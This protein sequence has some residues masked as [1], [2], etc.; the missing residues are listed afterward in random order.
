MH[1]TAF[2]IN[3]DLSYGHLHTT[4]IDKQITETF[5]FFFFHSYSHFNNV[6]SNK[7]I[8]YFC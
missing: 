4:I 8:E 1:F 2:P 7:I 3:K 5:L 6:S